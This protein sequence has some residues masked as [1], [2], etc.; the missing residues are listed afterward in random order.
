MAQREKAGD[1]EMAQLCSYWNG[2]GST[3]TLSTGV[4]G[5]DKTTFSISFNIQPDSL[6]DSMLLL[7]V[8]KKNGFL[9]RFLFFV[10]KPLPSFKEEQVRARRALKD[11]YRMHDVLMHTLIV[12]HRYHKKKGAVT[13]SLCPPA[14]RDYDDVVEQKVHDMRNEYK[15]DSGK[16]GKCS[17]Y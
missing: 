13:Y 10:A 12:I 4:R 9:D 3:S 8:D 11:R 14:Q 15:S 5:F 7:G 17:D 2:I 16:N 1:G 6:I